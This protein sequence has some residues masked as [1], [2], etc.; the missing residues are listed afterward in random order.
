MQRDRR[1]AVALGVEY[2]PP[3]EFQATNWPGL[4]RNKENKQ[5]LF[6]I[7]AEKCVCDPNVRQHQ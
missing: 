7:F 2:H 6:R 4:L 3:Q 1:E 5:E